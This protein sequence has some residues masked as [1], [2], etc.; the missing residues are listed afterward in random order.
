MSNRKGC[1]C[2][3]GVEINMTLHSKNFKGEELWSISCIGCGLR[4]EKYGKDNCLMHWN[5]RVTEDVR[6]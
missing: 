5:K 1:P 2:C 3:G 6:R 4:L